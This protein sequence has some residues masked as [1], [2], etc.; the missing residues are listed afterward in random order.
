[1]PNV[2][3]GEEIPLR[4]ASL[5]RKLGMTIESLA[6]QSAGARAQTAKTAAFRQNS[7]RGDAWLRIAV[8]G[9]IG[10]TAL[11]S[12]AIV[13]TS[14]GTSSGADSCIASATIRTLVVVSRTGE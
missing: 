14:R 10:H 4:C 2:R 11:N 6:L 5:P 9:L 8:S 3:C 7:N 13:F 1:M 12:S